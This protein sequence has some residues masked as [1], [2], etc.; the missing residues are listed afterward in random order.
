MDIVVLGID[1]QRSAPP[2]RAPPEVPCRRRW[3]AHASPRATAATMYKMSRVTVTTLVSPRG[4]LP[5]GGSPR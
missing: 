4:G 3:A 2:Q 5:H 1:T